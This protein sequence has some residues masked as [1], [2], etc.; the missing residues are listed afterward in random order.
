MKRH[1]LIL[2]VFPILL[3]GCG[4]FQ[5]ASIEEANKQFDLYRF[6]EAVKMY[7]ELYE[8]DDVKTEEKAVIAFK[9]AQSY[10]KMNKWRRAAS[11]Y[12]R[13]INRGYQDPEIHYAY[14][15]VLKHQEDYDQALEQYKKFKE[16]RPGDPRADQSI[17]SIDLNKKWDKEGT[18]YVVEEEKELNSRA[19]DYAPAYRRNERNLFFTS[20]RPSE[21]G[22]D[23][24]YRWTGMN[25]TDIYKA[26]WSRRQEKWGNIKRIEGD[27][28]T[29]YNDGVASFNDRGSKLYYTQC[30]GNEGEEYNCKIYVASKRGSGWSNPQILPFCDNPEDSMVKFGHPSLSDDGKKLFFSSDRE[31]GQGGRD[32]YVSHYVSRSRT[33]GEPTNLSAKI[34]TEGN[35]MFPFIHGNDKLYFASDGHAGLGG[36]D[37]F[38]SE[39]DG[40]SWSEP[41]NLKKPINSSADDFGII[42]NDEG[43]EGHF[44]SNRGGQVDNIYSFRLKPL[45]FTL[46]GTVYNERN[47]E[48]MKN[49]TVSLRSNI[50]D[51]PDT[52]NTDSTGY[53]EY[54]LEPKAHYEVDANK[55]DF[56]SSNRKLVSTMGL[57]ISKDFERDLY[58][59]P[60]PTEEIRIEGIYYGL[61][62]ANI[63]PESAQALDSLVQILEYNPGITIELRSHTDC[64]AS[65]D[66]N[67]D[68]SQRRADS[69]VNYLVKN[70]IDSARLEPEGYGEDSL[71]NNCRCENGQ[72]PGLDCTEEEHQEN[73]RTT[74]KIL[75]TDYE[76]AVEEIPEE[77]LGGEGG[78]SSPNGSEGSNE[79]MD[80]DEGREGDGAMQE[81][82][83][84]EQGG[85]E[86]R[87]GK[88]PDSNP[89]G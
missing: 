7:E 5:S 44:S 20:D 42:Y 72:G 75:S 54:D 65:K 38:V 25:F 18:R 1:F 22:N 48:P 87:E 74:F 21:E 86:F 37:I 79:G 63:R 43:K 13:A 64:R 33:W 49:A 26:D 81:N 34:N 61:D 70:D 27:V 88:S 9:T 66:Y 30:N 69:V 78:G 11:W 84:N 19:N 17:K 32:I 73:R 55:L 15:N 56:F 28:N 45:V 46:S 58:L 39:W 41:E 51:A 36:L 82:G 60:Q 59:Q 53:Y 12:K 85:E 52:V 77:D 35:E 89:G 31:E 71:V 62:S 14:G 57:E 83:A 47:D 40:E 68:L 16:A 2:F 4:L 50:S 76:P 23:D 8:S 6:A 29:E 10:S 67:R 3:S 80:G 24:K